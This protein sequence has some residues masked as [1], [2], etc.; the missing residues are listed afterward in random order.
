MFDESSIQIAIIALVFIGIGLMPLFLRFAKPGR[1][2]SRSKPG[3]VWL[4][5]VGATPDESTEATYR[6]AYLLLME[7][8]R[9]ELTIASVDPPKRVYRRYGA[10][11]MAQRVAYTTESLQP[12]MDEIRTLEDFG[13]HATYRGGWATFMKLSVHSEDVDK[14][15]RVLE[16]A[17]LTVERP[18]KPQPWH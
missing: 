13:R 6:S 2:P 17:G 16:R 8:L 18:T 14:A 9:M 7:G 10:P 12:H 15:E 5:I 3:Y 4:S 11:R 1:G